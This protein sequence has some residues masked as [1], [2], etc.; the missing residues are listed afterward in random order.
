MTKNTSTPRKPPGAS[1]KSRWNVTTAS[2]ATA[3]SPSRSD[4][5]APRR[6][7][8]AAPP[9]STTGCHD[10]AGPVRRPRPRAR[11]RS[12]GCRRKRASSVPGRTRSVASLHHRARRRRRGRHAA[13]GCVTVLRAI[14][15]AAC[16]GAV[17]DNHVD[18]LIMGAGIS[19]DRRGVPPHPRLPAAQLP[20]PRAAPGDRRHLGPVPLSRHPVRLGHVHLRLQL[21]AVAGDEGARRRHVDPRVRQRDRRRV[22]RARAHHASDARSWRADWSSATEPLDGRGP[23]R[24]ERRDRDVDVRV[25]HRLHRLLQLRQRLPARLPRRARLRRDLVHPQH[26]PDD[27]DYA[28]KRV[29]VIGSG[30]TAV[31]LVPAMAETA[32]HVTM[33]Q[34]SPSRTSSSLPAVDKIVAG[35]AEGASRRPRLPARARAQHRHPA[36]AV[37]HWRGA[38]RS[39]CARSSG[40]GAR[41]QL[42]SGRRPDATSPRST[43]RGTSGCASSPTAICSPRSARDAPTSSPTRSRRSRRPA[44]APRP[45]ASWRPT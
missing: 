4:E 10:G 13:A 26:W 15:F 30:A 42:G 22:R 6:R 24:G 37:R 40:R 3:R 23:R 41:R 29:L 35:A 38:V 17:P 12:R 18:V 19:G 32:A 16:G 36:R 34:R 20:H 9:G 31:T 1:E 7:A 45:G 8:A 25:P 44:C 21:P 39:S 28:G 14:P 11:A 2:T 43:T 33:L 27:L 5:P